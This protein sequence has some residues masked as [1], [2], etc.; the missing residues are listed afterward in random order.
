MGRWG[1]MWARGMAICAIAVG[2]S[3]GLAATGVSDETF[4]V[5]G[6]SVEAG[7]AARRVLATGDAR[8][9]PFAIVDKRQARLLVFGADGRLLGATP[10]LLGLAV[11]DHAVPGLGRR[12]G[13]IAPHE[14]TTPS[15]R[16]ES[17]PG[18]NHLG[19]AIVWVDY[20]AALAIHRL[21]PAA[22]QE[23][24]PQRLASPSPVDNRI[25]LG[26]II[27]E[28]GFY[29]AVVAPTLGRQRGVVYVLPESAPDGLDAMVLAIGARAAP[30][31]AG[32]SP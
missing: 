1:R 29:D 2:A 24:R 9:R 28:P 30:N 20:E 25:S 31:G 21:R 22:A 13:K 12:A 4:R 3:G 7:L 16:F 18:R 5:R 32:P 27:V 14:R 15:G 8:G 17:E 19:E 10:A 23:Q 6:I 26:C 11:G